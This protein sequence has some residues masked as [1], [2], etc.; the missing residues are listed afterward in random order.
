MLVCAAALAD[1]I[2]FKNGTYIQVDKSQENGNQIDYWIG[3][4]KYSASKADIEKIE[5]DSGP[6]IRLGSQ[7]E[8]TI[9]VPANGDR[10]FSI[11]ESVAR[12]PAS[13]FA[14][15]YVGIEPRYALEQAVVAVLQDQ[16]DRVSQ[17]L[18][19]RPTENIPVTLNM[20]RDFFDATQAPAWAGARDGKL[21]IPM[22]GIQEMTP[23]LEHVLRIEAGRA[24][25][26]GV[27][28]GRAPAWL[29][30]GL[31]Q[32]LEPHSSS[33]YLLMAMSQFQQNK[34]IPFADLEKPFNTLPPGQVK[35]ANAES[36]V[37][38]QYLNSKYGMDG[39]LRMMKETKNGAAPEVAL[40]RVTGSGYAELRG[41]VA[42]FLAKGGSK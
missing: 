18:K 28:G 1:T 6:G 31:A 41:Q 10:T 36:L 27:T 14:I 40:R 34:E 17:A 21:R 35:L 9:V 5:K 19:F 22:Q 37:L 8:G 3:S 11:S 23:A 39:I 38:M 33:P 4:T 26:H 16:Y 24:L 42:E 25:V 12:A 2:H 13:H 20:E 15:S 29:D 32:M 30:Q 7:S